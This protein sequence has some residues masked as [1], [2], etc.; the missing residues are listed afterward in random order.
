MN[1][2]SEIY[3]AYYRTAAVLLEKCGVT[4]K[5]VYSVINDEAFTDSALFIPLK[6]IPKNG[7]SDWGLL[8]EKDGKYVS[9]LKHKPAR[10]VTLL[11]KRWLKAQLDDPKFRLFLKDPDKLKERLGD[12]KP[13]Y[14][15]EIFRTTDAFA[16]GDPFEDE[17]YV[18]NFRTFA[19]AVHTG[20]LVETT[21]LSGRNETKHGVFLPLRLEYSRKND[22]FR[23]Y[24]VPE[25]TPKS[26]G[27]INLG[28]VITA[29]NTHRRND[30]EADL[31]DFFARR[32]CKEPV[33]VEVTS[34]R[35]GIE[36]FMMEFAAYEKH[37]VL[38]TETGVC[39]VKLWYDKADETELLIRLLSY[40]P[41]LRIISPKEFR[42]QAAERVRRQKE[43]L[44]KPSGWS[45]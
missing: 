44:V 3:G 10:I 13:L 5:D 24:C 25:G 17:N 11:Q 31:E 36:R 8:K 28:R 26:G 30:S 14:S 21:F 4:E 34:E 33:T 22:K 39:T 9:V 6:L 40:G 18:R 1:I 42:K 7:A 16:D 32:R 12:C 41:V 35:N 2:F 37:T 29:V 45:S 20:E 27:L 38:D 19:E 23:V 15:R 43:W